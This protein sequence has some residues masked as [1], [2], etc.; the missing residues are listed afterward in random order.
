MTAIQELSTSQLNSCVKGRFLNIRRITLDKVNDWY[1]GL[2]RKMV[3][4]NL[5]GA[6]FNSLLI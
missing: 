4:K 3:V 5:T 2:R 6:Y 1:N